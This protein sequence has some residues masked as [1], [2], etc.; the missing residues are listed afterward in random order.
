MLIIF[1]FPESIEGHKTYP[2]RPEAAGGRVF[3]TLLYA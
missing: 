2:G 3:E 1:K